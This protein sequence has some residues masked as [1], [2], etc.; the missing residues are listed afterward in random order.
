MSRPCAPPLSA[1]LAADLYVPNM[2]TSNTGF[3]TSVSANRSLAAVGAPGD[4]EF[5]HNAGAVYV[6]IATS[7]VT[8][9]WAFSEK[10][11]GNVNSPPG[12]GASV[13]VCESTGVVVGSA[14]GNNS[15]VRLPRPAPLPCVCVCVFVP[16]ACIALPC[17]PLLPRC[18]P[19]QPLLAAM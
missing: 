13:A 3:G 11:F 9:T 4:D 10:L 5:G 19:S 8:W 16:A 7:N 14:L 1:P 12:L 17:V 18:A 2:R 15:A 6:F